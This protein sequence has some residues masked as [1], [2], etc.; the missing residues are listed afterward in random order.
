MS[1]SA[2]RA[3]GADRPDRLIGDDQILARGAVR[4]GAGELADHDLQRPAG[5]ALG[6]ALADADDG[7][8]PGPP[9][10]LGL[11]AHQRDRSRHDRRAARN[12]RESPKP[13]AGV[14]DHLGGDVAGMGA[15]RIGVAVLR[16]DGEPRPDSDRRE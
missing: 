10:G 4:Y 5:I 11:E 7:D 6:L 14:R 2:G 15:A 9:S 1:A 13:R 12:G 8:E 3:P 16:A